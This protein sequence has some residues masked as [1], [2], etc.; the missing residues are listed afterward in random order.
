MMSNSGNRK[1][2]VRSSVTSSASYSSS[3]SASTPAP[4]PMFS[5]PST[6][7][8]V[9]VET[10]SWQVPATISIGGRRPTQHGPLPLPIA[11]KAFKP[12]SNHTGLTSA[13]TKTQVEFPPPPAVLG[14]Q[15]LYHFAKRFPVQAE[16]ELNA[17]PHKSALDYSSFLIGAMTTSYPSAPTLRAVVRQFRNFLKASSRITK[18]LSGSK[19]PAHLE[20]PRAR[21][22]TQTIRSLIWLKQY[23]RARVAVH[24]M[25][26][27][28][29]KPTGFAWRGICRGWIEQ[30]ELDRAEELAAKVFMDPSLSHDYRLDERP[31]YFTDMQSPSSSARRKHRSPMAPTSAPLFL[32]IEAL[33]ERGEMERARHWFDQIPENQLTDMLTSDMVAGYLKIGEK[34]KAQ[35]VIRI[36]A[37]CGVKPTAIVFNPIVEHAVNNMDMETAE[38]LVKD[39]LQLGIYLNLYTYKILIQGYLTAGQKSKALGCIERIFKSGIETDRA[40]GRILLDGL[41]RLGEVRQGDQGPPPVCSGDRVAEDYTLSLQP[42][43]SAQCK[44]WIRAGKMEQAEEVL[45]QALQSTSSALDPEVVRVI[46][47]LL[48]NQDMTRARYWY[49]RVIG[50]N[51]STRSGQDSNALLEL[52]NRVVAGFIR[53]RQPDEAEVVLRTMAQ[54]GVSPTVDTINAILDWSTLQADMKDAEG[55]VGQLIQSGLAPNQTTFEILCRGYA[56]HGSLE[57]MAECLTSMEGAGYSHQEESTS[58]ADLRASLCGQG[59]ADLTTPLGSSVLASLCERWVEHGQMH[60]AEVFVNQ[61]RSNVHVQSSQIPYSTLIQGWI[62]QSQQHQVTPVAIETADRAKAKNSDT[63]NSPPSVSV[64]TSASL[65]QEM[66]WRQDSLAKI[67]KARSWFDKVPEE[68]LSVELVNQMIGG[69]VALGLE[70]E[71]EALIQWMATKKIKPDVQT[72]NNILEYTVQKQPMS[73]AEELVNKMRTKAEIA[74]NVDTWNLLIRGYVVRGQLLPALRC[75]DRMMGRD[76]LSNI[77]GP[78]NK[79]KSKSRE[80]IDDYDR[81]ILSAVVQGDEAAEEIGRGVSGDAKK[82]GSEAWAGFVEP[83]EATELLILSGFGPESKPV[84]GHGDYA[85]ALALYRGRVARQ[86]Q[87]RESLLQ[88][89]SELG[90]SE[91]DDGWILDHMQTWEGLGGSGSELGMTDMDWK[92]ELEWEE[93]MEAEK[94]RERELSGARR[95]RSLSI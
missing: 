23:R 65:E 50:Q 4:T 5:F 88:G 59:Q 39:M 33:T 58:I 6:L 75:L 78:K 80:I 82:R 38:D 66:R 12:S 36:M 25:Q 46:E 22:W 44:E 8:P 48:E 32:V 45:E 17:L 77:P 55:I 83:N 3:V 54:H 81:D 91:G 51:R 28:G 53:A 49:N 70:D 1:S 84:Q 73:T 76:R 63:Q 57:S 92:N 71:F 47:E 90:T 79:S 30:G 27:L 15:P 60:R 87:Q 61:L 86:S 72:Y 34:D 67:R 43:W 62:D 42:G 64:P 93:L 95:R 13:A 11:L 69:Y 89:L 74:P 18:D 52:S 20:L 14:S 2:S 21:I 19:G 29:I 31:Y 16:K 10:P 24:A 35:E 94:E 41:W 26:K 9:P 68:D 37:R 85:R 40:L 7:P 56:S